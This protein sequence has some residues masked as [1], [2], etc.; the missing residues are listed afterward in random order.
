M[1]INKENHLFRN[2]RDEKETSKITKET[3]NNKLFGPARCK[4]GNL[5]PWSAPVAWV[6]PRTAQHYYLP[7]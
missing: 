4:R 6:H 5:V 1:N 7:Y 2:K 3:V